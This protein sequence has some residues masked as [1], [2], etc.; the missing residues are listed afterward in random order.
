MAAA[1]FQQEDIAVVIVGADRVAANGDTANKIG[2]YALAILARHHGIKFLVAAP[3]TTIDLATAS[4]KDITIELRPG[5]EVK[6]VSGPRDCG[7]GDID[8][9]HW[10]TVSTA[11]KRIRAWNPSFDV[12][13][14]GLIDGIV[15]EV[16]VVEKG[17][18]GI[19]HL[20]RLFN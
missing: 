18:D 1:L 9:D 3:R 19:F 20:D 8:P 15:T 12:T 7:K 4:G 14:A 10:E 5:E 6:R 11:P 17:S 16:G 13:P 2:T